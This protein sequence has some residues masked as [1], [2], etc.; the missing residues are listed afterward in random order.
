MNKRAGFSPIEVL[1]A[2]TIFAMLV[3]VIVGAFI[4]ARESTANAGVRARAVYLAEEGLE[5]ARNIR[6][7]AYANL[8]LGTY[9]L[10]QSGG[11]W[12]LGGSVDTTGIYTR[13]LTVAAANTYRKTVTSTVT[14]PQ[15]VGTGSVSGVTEFANWTSSWL[16]A[17]M[18]GS[19]DA[20]G[21]TDGL[22][23]ATVGNY[24]YVVRGGGSP[25][26]MILNISNP[27][28]PALVGSLALANTPTNITVSGNYAYVVGTSP[29]AELQIIAINNPATPTVV[30]TWNSSGAGNGLTIAVSGNYAYIGQ[31]SSQ[32]SD[33]FMVVNVSNP[34]APTLAGS[35]SN[36]L[37]MNG[38]VLSGNYAFVGT[39]KSSAELLT[40][41]ISNPAAPTLANSFNIPGAG[42][43]NAIALAGTTL[44]AVHGSDVVAINVSNPIA[45]VVLGTVTSSGKKTTINDLAAK[46]DSS[47]VFLGTDDPT[48]EFQVVNVN[49]PTNMSIG[50][51][52]DTA[53]IVQGIA[54]NAATDTVVAA[55]TADTQEVI[56]MVRS[57]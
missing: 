38:I 31:A 52:V 29:T 17:V 16:T 27:A 13:S 30:G 28:A 51:V 41:D 2:A 53:G 15:A 39:D 45:P 40:L 33:E 18:A 12:T 48:G 46:P 56:T 4:F 54:W 32:T 24:A 14:W 25:N 50:R 26:F 57:E 19:Y 44:F 35:Y 21:T 3:T 43:V 20:A 55:T 7:S 22:K 6:D 42:N 34:A 11:V 5:A 37:A 23:V 49:D 36:K 10:V 9:G 47:F 8:P 1:L